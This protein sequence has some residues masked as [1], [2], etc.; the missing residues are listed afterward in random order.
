MIREKF[1]S[2]LIG[3]LFVAVFQPFGLS[4]LGSRRLPL[5][6]GISSVI[7][8][9]CIVCEYAVRLLFPLK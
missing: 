8:F 1:I 7:V 6:L 3:A 5:L 2:G 4:D 9:S